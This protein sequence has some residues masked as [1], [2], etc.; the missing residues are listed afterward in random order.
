MIDGLSRV[1]AAPSVGLVMLAS[2]ASA[3]VHC[4]TIASADASGIYRGD[5]SADDSPG[6]ELSEPK[7]GTGRTAGRGL[8]RITLRFTRASGRWVAARRSAS[9][10]SQKHQQHDGAHRRG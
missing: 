5:E 1:C 4:N 7:S 8:S 3:I 2:C 6:P 9:K 10:Q